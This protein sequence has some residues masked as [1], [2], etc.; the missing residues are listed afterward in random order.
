M[1][2]ANKCTSTVQS[3]NSTVKTKW[4]VCEHFDKCDRIFYVDNEKDG[5]CEKWK[6]KEG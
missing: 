5:H 1:V 2:E 6:Y 3:E 4:L